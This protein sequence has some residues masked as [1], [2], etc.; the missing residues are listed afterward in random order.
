V[1]MLSIENN[2]YNMQGKKLTLTPSFQFPSYVVFV[3]LDVNLPQP[4]EYIPCH[5]GQYTHCRSS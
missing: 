5:R 4:V 3:S 2:R 1:G